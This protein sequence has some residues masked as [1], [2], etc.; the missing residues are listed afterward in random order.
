MEEGRQRFTALNRRH[1]TNNHKYSKYSRQI[2]NFYTYYNS[3]NIRIYDGNDEIEAGYHF[4]SQ[5]F[6]I[7]NGS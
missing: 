4:G 2:L 3:K 5:A 1:L 7:S 6:F